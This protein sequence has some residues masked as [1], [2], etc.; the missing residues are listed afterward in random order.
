MGWESGRRQGS[1]LG[2]LAWPHSEFHLHDGVWVPAEDRAFAT[3]LARSC[4]RHLVAL[5]RLAYRA[6]TGAVTYQSD[7]ASGPTAAAEIVD[8]LEFLARV[9]SHIPKAEKHLR[10]NPR[11]CGSG[12]RL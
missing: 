4:A 11:E 9:V 12:D 6:D 2:M 7:K 10:C 3:G 5:S 8:V 1:A